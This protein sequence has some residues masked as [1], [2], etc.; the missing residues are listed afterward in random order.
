MLRNIRLDATY[1]AY[2]TATRNTN[3]FENIMISSL[4]TFRVGI[5]DYYRVTEI[6][7]AQSGYTYGMLFFNSIISALPG[8]QVTIGYYVAELLGLSFDGIGAATTIL[9]MFY[10]DG[11]VVLIYVGM[12]LFGAF[13]QHFYK[14]Y[15][16]KNTIS[17]EHLV[18][19]YI[20]FYAINSLRTNVLPNI[21]PI[22]AIFYYWLFGYI[23]KKTS[24]NR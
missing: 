16:M 10:I 17:I 24:R 8:K 13:V 14:A 4:N 5:D 23:I 21:E 20:L 12:L 11:G 22:M 3:I 2:I 19:V 1:L 15:I 6:V 7:P 18:G 9:G